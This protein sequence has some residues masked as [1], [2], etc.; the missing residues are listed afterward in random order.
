MPET[1]ANTS[2]AGAGAVSS[3]N[4]QVGVVVLDTGDLAE[5]TDKKYV[6]DAEKTKLSNLSNTNTGDQDLSGKVDKVVGSSLVA[7]TEIAKIHASGS[8]NQDLS[9][10]E[11]LSNKQTDLTASAT[12]YPTVNAVNTGLATKQAAGSYEPAK[13]TDDNYVTDAQL[14]VIG[15]TSGANTGDQTLPTDATLTVTDVTTN[16]VSTSKHGWFPK[17]PTATGLF[18]KDDL[19]WAAPAT[20]NPSDGDK[21]DL[22]VASGVWTID[23]GVI[24]EAKQVL[25]DNTTNDVSTSKH[26]YVPK[27]PNTLLKF[28]SDD[29][30]WKSPYIFV[31][32]SAGATTTGADTNPVS[33]SG[34]VFTYVNNAIYMIWVMGRVNSTAATTGIG[35]QFDLSTAITDINVIGINTLAAAGTVSGFGSIADDTSQSVSSGV[36]A[37]PLDAALFATAIFRPG[38]NTGTC[39]LRVRSETTAVTEL[40]AGATMVVERIA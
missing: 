30:T 1:S 29:G 21:G 40:M 32:T 3:V 31:G 15:N 12:K 5:V 13:G 10:Y 2:S 22:T 38:N 19:T 20:G 26:G 34:L 28:L 35:I 24:T 39:Q 7:D 36:P 17:L 25:A 14:V 18:L 27:A 8:D 6:S 11:L 23:A 16:N 33:V 4:S 37:G 9:G